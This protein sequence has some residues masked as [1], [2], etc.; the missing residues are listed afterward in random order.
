MVGQ[1]D[2]FFLSNAE[3]QYPNT[4][5]GRKKDAAGNLQKKLYLDHAY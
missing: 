4:E 2:I 1:T 5:G 3:N